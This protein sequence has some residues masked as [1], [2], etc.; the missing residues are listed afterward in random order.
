MQPILSVRNLATEIPT[1]RGTLRVV[2]RVSF[3]LA[4]GE[5]L[6][7]VGESGSGK[8]MTCRSLLGLVPG[9]GRAVAGEVLYDGRDLVT[10]SE[11][12]LIRVRGKEIAVI[13][14]DAVAALNP[15]WRIGDQI[16][17]AMVE[18]GVAASRSEA[19]ERSIELMR[20]VGIPAPERRI[21]DYPHQFSGGMCQRVVIAAALACEPR[22]LIADEP[23]TALDVTIQDQILKLLLSLQKDLGLSIILVTHDMG[24]V[25][26]TCQRVAVMYGG[27]IVETA[28]TDALF[29]GPRHPYTSGLLACMPDLET[30]GE[31]K[32]LRP[33]PGMPPDLSDPPAGC[34]FH[35]RCPLAADVCRAGDVPFAE[36]SPGHQTRCLRH[37]SLA[38]ADIWSGVEGVPA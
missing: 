9:G 10:L 33:I 28:G 16:G 37:E 27:R 29:A 2:D 31:A 4:P 8:S 1:H 6:G 18:H 25:A 34:S 12:Q 26:Q 3:D 36:I 20:M 38:G 7:I 13:V 30:A 32:R 5:C 21:D 11:K 24:V 14:Q 35:P 22:I 23:T 17:E 15:V 19:R